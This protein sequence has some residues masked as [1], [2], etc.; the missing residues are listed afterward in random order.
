MGRVVK[1]V[2]S[3]AKGAAEG[4][5]VSEKVKEALQRLASG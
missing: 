5:T 2:M 4:K 1:A 3:R